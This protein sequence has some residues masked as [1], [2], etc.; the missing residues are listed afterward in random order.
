MLRLP[1]LI[2]PH[3]HMREPGATHKED[4]M[5][6]SAT[7][8]ASGFTAVL[9][10]PNTAPPVCDAETLSQTLTLASQKAHCDYAQYMGAGEENA[11]LLSKLAGQAAGLKLYLDQTY[12]PLRLTDQAAWLSHF[13]CWPV[14]KPLCIHAEGETLAAALKLAE[15]MKRPVHFC[16]VSRKDEIDLIRVAKE[17]GAAVTCEVTPHHLFLTDADIPRSARAALKCVRGW[18]AWLTSRRFGITWR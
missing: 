2:D 12:G 8:L 1:G 4:W 11:S 14:Y 7:A 16:H 17:R 13:E 15:E 18:Q 5:S 6:G 3:V 10:M 9:A